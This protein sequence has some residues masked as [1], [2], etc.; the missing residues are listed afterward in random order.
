MNISASGGKHHACE[1]PVAEHHGCQE[2]GGKVL[3]KLR[4]ART[5]FLFVV[6]AVHA[7][8]CWGLGLN[9]EGKLAERRKQKGRKEG[10][11]EGGERKGVKQGKRKAGKHRG[12]T[13]GRRDGYRR[14]PCLGFMGVL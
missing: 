12:R 4:F 6:P 10:R 14:F 9:V 7:L 1:G 2:F 8:S 5:A 3:Y 11:K 13:R